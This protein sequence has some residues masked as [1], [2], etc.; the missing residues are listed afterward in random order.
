LEDFRR[1]RKL[2]ADVRRELVSSQKPLSSSRK[3]TEDQEQLSE[4]LL[5]ELEAQRECDFMHD[6]FGKCKN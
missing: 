5:V 2:L 3:K 4:K 6:K 1:A